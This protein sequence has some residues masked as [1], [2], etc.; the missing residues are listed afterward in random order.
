MQ[1]SS[2]V[3]AAKKRAFPHANPQHVPDGVLLARLNSVD[4]DI[5]NRVAQEAPSVLSEEASK[6]AVTSS[7]NSS[8]YT[9]NPAASYT[10][11]ELVEDDDG[12]SIPIRILGEGDLSN[13]PSHPSGV[14]GPDGSGGYA[15]FPADPQEEGWQGG[16]DRVYYDPDE[17]SIRYRYIPAHT[18]LTSLSDELASPDF[19]RP[20]LEQTLVV[21]I[22]SAQPAPPA[23]LEQEIQRERQL[24]QRVWINLHKFAKQNTT[25]QSEGISAVPIHEQII[26]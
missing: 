11:F 18:E 2:V 24:W 20:Y 6:V 15:F 26:D 5:V 7:N 23:D 10:H 25:Q 14:V 9:L 19:V 1:A 4:Q 17:H 13:P 3:D 8:G 22:K 21:Q 16:D 12:N